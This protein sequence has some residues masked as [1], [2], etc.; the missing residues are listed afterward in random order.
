M[1]NTSATGGIEPL[2]VISVPT[3]TSLLCYLF[4]TVHRLGYQRELKYTIHLVYFLHYTGFAN[5]RELKYTTL[6]KSIGKPVSMED[7]WLV[8]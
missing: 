8:S 5:Q 3:S 4:P 7:L 2:L 6:G 1:S